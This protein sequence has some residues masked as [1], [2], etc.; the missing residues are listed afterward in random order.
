MNRLKVREGQHHDA[1]VIVVTT[2]NPG[3]LAPHKHLRIPRRER[4]RRAT[5]RFRHAMPSVRFCALA[6]Q[7]GDHLVAYGIWIA[8][9]Y[10]QFT[11]GVQQTF[12]N[13]NHFNVEVSAD[14]NRGFR[15]RPE[16]GVRAFRVRG[17]WFCTQFN[18][19]RNELET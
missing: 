15:Q 13:R 10:E 1:R 16:R 3:I 7:I 19:W 4:Q 9:G 14:G 12:E 8:C 17:I 18:C 6:D 5:L 11:T 2:Q